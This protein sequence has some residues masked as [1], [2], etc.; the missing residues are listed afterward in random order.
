MT[1]KIITLGCKMNAYESEALKEKLLANGFKETND[2]ADCYIVNTCAV[3]HMAEKKD[4][5]TV[6]DIQRDHPDSKIFVMGCSSQIHKEMYLEIENVKAV[7]GTFHK[8]EMAQCIMEGRTPGD[9]V[10]SDFR[11]FTFD[12]LSISKGKHEARSYIKIQDGCDNFCSY[13]IVPYSRGRSRSR[14]HQ[15][16]MEEMKRLLD[17]G[18]K[19]I[20]IGG[21]DVGSYEDPHEEKAYRLKNLLREMAEY[22]PEKHFRIRV[23]SIE[24]SQIDDEYI[25]LFHDYPNRLCPHF[26][27][28]LQS[29]SEKILIKMNRKYRLDDFYSM[30][31]KIKKNIANVALS[32]DVISGFPGETDEDF[33]N[34]YEFIK[35]VGFMR[36]H[37]FPYSER[38]GTVA[39]RI[40]E[41][42]V[43]MDIRRQRTNK[44]IDLGVIL[45]KNFRADMKGKNLE[46][47]FEGKDKD[48]LY[49]GYTENYLEVHSKSEENLTNQF[50]KIK[51]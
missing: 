16:I 32:T 25:S 14:N 33:E 20:I 38:E 50:K 17:N 19:E 46:V 12:N 36:I 8:D 15:S 1:F 47:L 29:G 5:K 28:P 23:S 40:K 6:R 9:Q 41:G 7:Y 27:I 26:H 39:S 35:K 10:N 42:I 37:A 4:M 18:V 13:C 30:T 22:A 44:L 3:T 31:E 49:Q 43:R 11:S 45:E 48:G 51:F 34:T 24:C 21:I 2:N